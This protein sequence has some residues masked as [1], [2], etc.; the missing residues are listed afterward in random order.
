MLK[1][2]KTLAEIR[3]AFGFHTD[4]ANYYIEKKNRLPDHANRR[5]SLCQTLYH[6]HMQQRFKL[7]V[8]INGGFPVQMTTIPL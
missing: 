7:L 3:A 5:K 8:K 4:R 1:T 2:A 6:Y